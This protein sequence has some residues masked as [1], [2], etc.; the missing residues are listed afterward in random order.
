MLARVLPM[1]AARGRVVLLTSRVLQALTSTCAVVHVLA[2]A[3]LA[4]SYAGDDSARPDR[5]LLAGGVRRRVALAEEPLA[6]RG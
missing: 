2:D 4:G 6:D 5:D 3:R 1:V